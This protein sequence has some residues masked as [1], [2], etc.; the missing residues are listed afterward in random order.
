MTPSP[1]WT[2]REKLLAIKRIIDRW[3]AGETPEPVR[4]PED[5]D[6]TAARLREAHDHVAMLIMCLPEEL[7]I[8]RESL[9]EMIGPEEEGEIDWRIE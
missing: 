6:E 3:L 2:D 5:A 1:Q 8:H 9:M 4:Q 7:E